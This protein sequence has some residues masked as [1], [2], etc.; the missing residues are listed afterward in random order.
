MRPSRVSTAAQPQGVRTM[1]WGYER[2]REGVRKNDFADYELNIQS[3]QR[4]MDFENLG[5]DDVRTSVKRRAIGL[6]L[7]TTS[8]TANSTVLLDA[9]RSRPKW[10]S[11]KSPT[12]AWRCE[13]DR[14][15]AGRAGRQLRRHGARRAGRGL[16]RRLVR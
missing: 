3:L 4:G 11:T 10:D 9:A 2:A 13:P 16:V 7:V 8:G 15:S 1:G 14:R 5:P 6:G 12:R